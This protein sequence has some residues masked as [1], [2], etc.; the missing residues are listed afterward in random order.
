MAAISKILSLWFR[1]NLP[2]KVV[3]EVKTF[4]LYF[5]QL[6][7]QVNTSIKKSIIK[8]VFFLSGLLCISNRLPGAA[9]TQRLVETLFF[10][11]FQ[12]FFVNF[13]C[14]SVILH[15]KSSKT[16]EKQC[17]KLIFKAVQHA[18]AGGLPREVPRICLFSFVFKYFFSYFIIFWLILLKKVY[19]IIHYIYSMPYLKSFSFTQSY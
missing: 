7:C 18:K 10:G 11:R 17:F 8:L 16:Y 3:C 13:K 14:F 6:W 4:V 19:Q 5:N 15:L 9:Y 1:E 12:H 2:L